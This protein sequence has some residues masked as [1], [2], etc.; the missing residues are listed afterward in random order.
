MPL[1][2]F[3][4]K[5]C[6]HSFEQ[7]VFSGDSPSC[8]KCHGALLEKKWSIP[9]GIKVTESGACNNSLPPC[10]PNC[11]KLQQNNG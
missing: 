9:G 3:T 6:E 7:L 8:P 11:C 5:K 2:E 10:N 4:C 1:Y